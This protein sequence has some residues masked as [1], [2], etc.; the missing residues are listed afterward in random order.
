MAFSTQ[1]GRPRKPALDNDPGTPELRLKHALR[2]TAEPIDLCLEKNLITTE[3]HW[4]GLH[5]RWL[6]TLRYGAPSLTTHYT[7]HAAPA[8]P[9]P[10]DDPTWRAMREQE[11]HDAITLL[12]NHRRYE[13][14]MRLTVFNEHPAF[15]SP[16][17][18]ER[19]LH[20]PAV[21][22]QLANAHTH[23][24]EGLQL[25]VTHWRR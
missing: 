14:V 1:R 24:R 25:L 17:M 16:L 20:S 23:L 3:Q 15:L 8:S 6:Y 9:P 22:N 18:R 12:K 21:T 5:M 4:C 11:Y 13:C 7:D 19:A 2:F 10:N